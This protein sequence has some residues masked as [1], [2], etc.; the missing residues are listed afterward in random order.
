MTP[1]HEDTPVTVLLVSQEISVN[2]I[3]T[4]AQKVF[5]KMEYVRTSFLDLLANARHFLQET[6]VIWNS[7]RALQEMRLAILLER[8]SASR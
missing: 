3:L 6:R 5:A 7:T 1:T 4:N 2:P 8:I